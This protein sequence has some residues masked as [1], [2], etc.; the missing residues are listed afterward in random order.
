M[1]QKVTLRFAFQYT[2]PGDPGGPERK[3]DQKRG[4]YW[5]GPYEVTARNIPEAKDVLTDVILREMRRPASPIYQIKLL[6]VETTMKPGRDDEALEDVAKGV[7]WEFW[8]RE[9]RRLYPDGPPKYRGLDE[10]WDW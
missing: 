7:R 3:V 5:S 2:L 4:I 6:E 10:D 8:R 9:V 1:A